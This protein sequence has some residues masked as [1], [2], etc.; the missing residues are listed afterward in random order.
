MDEWRRIRLQ[1]KGDFDIPEIPGL[2]D[3]QRNGHL[4]VLTTKKYR[5]GIE[6]AFNQ[7]GASVTAVERMTLE[8]VFLTSVSKNRELVQ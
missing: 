5:Q 2:V 1:T 7:E 3:V 4:T 6:N 8:E